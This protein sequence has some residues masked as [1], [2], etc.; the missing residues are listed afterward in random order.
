MNLVPGVLAHVQP[1][2]PHVRQQHLGAGVSNK[3]P[4][5]R[6]DSQLQTGGAAPVLQLI[7]EELHGHGFI[8]PEGLLQ[9]VHC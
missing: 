7:G 1:S 3:G 8:L 5:V 9:Q 6:G 4:Q 2:H